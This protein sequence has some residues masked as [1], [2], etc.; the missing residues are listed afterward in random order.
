MS[1]L[2]TVQYLVDVPT[3]E[4]AESAVTETANHASQVIDM[5]IS[6]TRPVSE[7]I[8]QSIASDTYK[9][10][11]AFLPMV[12]F[13]PDRMQPGEDPLSAQAFW[14]NEYGWGTYDLATRLDAS[15]HALPDGGLVLIDRGPQAMISAVTRLTAE[16]EDKALAKVECP[17]T[18]LVTVQLGRD[19]VWAVPDY[20]ECQADDAEHA[21]KLARKAYRKRTAQFVRAVRV[22]HWP[23]ST[24]FVIFSLSEAIAKGL[25][26]DPDSMDVCG[27]LQ[28]DGSWGP[29]E[30][31]DQYTEIEMAKS[32][33]L[34][35]TRGSDASWIP[36]GAH[37][38]GR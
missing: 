35:Q 25:P 7:H 5:Q 28:R 23:A 3:A 31:A 15:Q 10:G 36:L 11:D 27:Y 2:I 30:T 14:S 18:F 8:A 6:D 21:L 34:P 26:E 38:K 33:P 16:P 12:V 17:Y 13:N 29:L 4:A 19:N 22:D 1:F 24:R 20:F 9:N 32:G 37:R